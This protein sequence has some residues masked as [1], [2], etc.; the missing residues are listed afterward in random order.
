MRFIF[1]S[2]E[3]DFATNVCRSKDLF[4][5]GWLK[6]PRRDK[7][8]ATNMSSSIEKRRIAFA[9]LL[10][11]QLSSVGTIEI[12]MVGTEKTGAAIL[13]QMYPSN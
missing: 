3:T 6:K 13:T 7:E 2:L 1:I 9:A 5:Q 10:K 8:L 11:V 4:E 12:S